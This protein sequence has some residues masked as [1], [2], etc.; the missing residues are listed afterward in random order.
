MKKIITLLSIIILTSC[1]KETI[2]LSEED[3]NT[4]EWNAEELTK[5]YQKSLEHLKVFEDQGQNVSAQRQRISEQYKL[6]MKNAC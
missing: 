4:C 6:R 3:V 2:Y 5:S 1:T